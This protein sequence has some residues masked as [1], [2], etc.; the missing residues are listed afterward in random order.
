MGTG[1][2]KSAANWRDHL[3]DRLDQANRVLVQLE[4]YRFALAVMREVGEHL[5]VIDETEVDKIK[6]VVR[7]LE[8][9]LDQIRNFCH[10]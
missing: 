10:E 6:Q 7:D 4:T 8:I 9:D 1:Q 2:D 5:P 3:D